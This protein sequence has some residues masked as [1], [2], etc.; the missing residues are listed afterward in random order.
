M[1]Q[2][3][4]ELSSS[5]RLQILQLLHKRGLTL[6]KITRHIGSISNSEMSRHLGRLLERGFIKKEN[7][8]GKDYVLTEF[9][10]IICKMLQP[11][12]FLFQND[13]YF[14]THSLLDLPE[15]LQTRINCLKRAEIIVGT[16]NV[17]VALQ[18]YIQLPTNMLRVMVDS[19]F[20][21]SN[22][23]NDVDYICSENMKLRKPNFQ[24]SN[25]RERFKF[26]PTAPISL[27]FNNLD[28]G[29]I[30]F[31]LNGSQSP[32]YSVAFKV[33]DLEGIQYL[34]D[35]WNYYWNRADGLILVDSN[36]P[37]SE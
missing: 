19:P 14:S 21:F 17:M 10:R 15:F 25:K 3:F 11:I 8:P 12:I 7:P 22:P 31:P 34:K 20:P 29:L 26:L 5:V 18:E 33:G 37:F 4:I 1:E 36:H 9:G 24:E 23:N 32:D 2:Y 6:S 13:E 30:I 27:S 16:G 35:I 28:R